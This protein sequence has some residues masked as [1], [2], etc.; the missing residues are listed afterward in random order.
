M[1]RILSS[2]SQEPYVRGLWRAGS[3]ELVEVKWNRYL[4]GTSKLHFDPTEVEGQDVVFFA[5]FS[6][7]AEVLRQWAVLCAIPRYGA[8]SL[9]IVLPFFPFATQDRVDTEGD[10]VM[11][12]TVARLLEA[13]PFCHGKGPARLVIYDIHAQQER[14]FFGDSILVKTLEL[15][16]SMVRFQL[17]M[18]ENADTLIAFPD[19][20]AR[21]RFGKRFRGDITCEK[22]RDPS[23][24]LKRHITIIEG[25]PRGRKVLI[26]DD[27]IQTGGTLI[28]CARRLL[29]AG[30]VSV[31]AYATHAVLPDRS[32]ER[33]V[34]SP[35]RQITVTDTN[36]TGVDRF[37]AGYVEGVGPKRLVLPMKDIYQ[38]LFGV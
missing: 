5:D 21:K 38:Q 24:P 7:E 18:D 27:L 17:L 32:M 8:N 33:L 23:D 9:T 25:D 30:A 14:F 10:I 35:L 15:P 29:E 12:R 16:E 28:E 2:A 31:S 19:A 3:V 20:G 34:D 22:T 1:L 13:V 6:D 36:P 37:L 4:D 11:A 26:I